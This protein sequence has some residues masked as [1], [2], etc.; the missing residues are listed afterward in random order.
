MICK[1]ISCVWDE[2]NDYYYY[3]SLLGKQVTEYCMLDLNFNFF[4][5]TLKAFFVGNYKIFI[6]FFSFHSF[7]YYVK[8]TRMIVIGL[9]WVEIVQGN[10]GHHWFRALEKLRWISTCPQIFLCILHKIQFRSIH[11]RQAVRTGKRLTKKY[12]KVFNIFFQYIEECPITASQKKILYRSLSLIASL[13]L[14]Y[15]LKWV[16]FHSQATDLSISTKLQAKT[17]WIMI[18]Q[19]KINPAKLK[20]VWNFSYPQALVWQFRMKV[21]EYIGKLYRNWRTSFFFKVKEVGVILAT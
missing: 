7:T 17:H 10:T 14:V 12:L 15:L 1:Y 16:T 13:F 18:L 9:I 6:L 3:Y 2:I 21:A 8:T 20:S 11:K 19:Q 4:R 5:K